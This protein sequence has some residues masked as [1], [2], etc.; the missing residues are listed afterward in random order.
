MAETSFDAVAGTLNSKMLPYE[1]ITGSLSSA[2]TEFDY[3][4]GY[5]QSNTMILS[6]EIYY[7]SSD[8]Y[9]Y[10]RRSL[11]R[12]MSSKIRVSLTDSTFVGKD[13]RLLITK[14]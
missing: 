11:V 4:T 1:I 6:F 12:L 3:P 14:V 7:S 5:D 13:V 10:D 8:I 9:S 2:D